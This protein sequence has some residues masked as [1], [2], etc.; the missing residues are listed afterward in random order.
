M[1]FKMNPNFESEAASLVRRATQDAVDVTARVHHEGVEPNVEGRLRSEL[2]KRG[3]N[4][5]DEEWLKGL[6]TQIRE[7]KVV[8][9]TDP[10]EIGA[11][12]EEE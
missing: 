12:V 3:I 1:A 2:T 7:S 6:A 9:V 11:A 5:T 4:I 10:N 8:I